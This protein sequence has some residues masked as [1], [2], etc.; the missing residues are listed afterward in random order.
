[1]KNFVLSL[2]LILGTTLSLCVFSA[3][4]QEFSS[5]ERK[6]AASYFQSVRDNFA[7]SKNFSGTWIANT[8]R[9]ALLKTYSEEKPQTFIQGAIA[10]LDKCPVDAKVHLMLASLLLRT[11]DY[12]GS[13]Y[14][15]SMFYGLLWSTLAS[16]DGKTPKTAF[17]VIASD[18]EYT[19]LNFIGAKLKQQSL[20]GVNDVM[21]VELDGKVSVMYF[22]VSIGLDFLEKK[23][24][25]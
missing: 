21:E 20:Q 12:Q 9:E 14:H 22:D 19:V 7:K 5:P 1:M 23:L 17:H 16:G 15:R 3:D 8:Q 6:L 2:Q 10:W 24:T 18:E 4:S 13:V 25:Q 11:G